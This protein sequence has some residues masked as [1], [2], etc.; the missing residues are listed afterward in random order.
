MTHRP[1]AA[2]LAALTTLALSQGLVLTG[3]AAA[4]SAPGAT[5]ATGTRAEPQAKPTTLRLARLDRG[6]DATQPYVRGR[7]ILDGADSTRVRGRQLRLLGT[8]P[9]G[10]YVVII[11]RGDHDRVRAVQPGGG[12]SKILGSTS[13]LEV[14]LSGDGTTL[15]TGRFK[16]RSRHTLLRAY[17]S[18]TGELLGTRKRKGY[19]TT[20]DSATDTVLY[21][22]ENGPVVAWDLTTDT[23]ERV[24]KRYGYRADLAHD[25]LAVFTKDPYEGG[26]TVVSSISDPGTTLWRSCDEAVWHFSTDGSHIATSYILA[27]GLGP[28]DVTV[29]TDE[30]V[31]TG[32]YRVDNG[33]FRSLFFEDADTLLLDTATEQASG[34]VRCDA[35]RCELASDLGPGENF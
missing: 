20:L 21:S 24:T 19:L 28:A 2:A 35:G 27:D 33:Y 18:T 31:R 22:G 12:S 8:R 16:Y 34:V 26:C 32:R 25:R 15:V 23:G 6:A 10:R 7:R 9:D 13:Q 1:L 11:Q 17:D 4:G 3:S 14:T 30:G 29:R 5:A